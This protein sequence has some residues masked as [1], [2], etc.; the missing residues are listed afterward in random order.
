[1]APLDP[2]LKDWVKGSEPVM[3]PSPILIWWII[4]SAMR[5]NRNN[6][7]KSVSMEMT[8]PKGTI[9]ADTFQCSRWPL[10]N[11]AFS[12]NVKEQ[13]CSFLCSYN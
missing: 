6:F 3:F 11:P 4:S 13:R 12:A 5:S 1:M 2:A 7:P 9:P 8:A 10:L